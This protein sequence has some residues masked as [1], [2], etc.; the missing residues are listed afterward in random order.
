MVT[1]LTGAQSVGG[2]R[3]VRAIIQ[4]PRGVPQGKEIAIA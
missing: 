3:A 4:F 1:A 2:V